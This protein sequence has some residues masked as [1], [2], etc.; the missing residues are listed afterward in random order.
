MTIVHYKGDKLSLCASPTSSSVGI[1]FS[2]FL[3]AGYILRIVEKG[4]LS[5]PKNFSL[6]SFSLLCDQDGRIVLDDGGEAA[7]DQT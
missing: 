3:H 4:S 5:R 1:C 2:D 6:E 7:S